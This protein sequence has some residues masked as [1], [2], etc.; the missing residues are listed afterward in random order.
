M[1]LR[2]LSCDCVPKV[3]KYIPKIAA[4]DTGR[5]PSALHDGPLSCVRHL[6]ALALFVFMK[7]ALNALSDAA[8]GC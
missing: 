2:L 1:L 8:F 4:A 3:R 6:S 7:T 5:N